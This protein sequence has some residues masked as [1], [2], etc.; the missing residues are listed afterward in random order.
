MNPRRFSAIASVL[1]GLLL[2]S[3]ATER[4]TWNSHE[5]RGLE[6][7]EHFQ[8]SRLES[9][10]LP[11]EGAVASGWI[12]SFGDERLN[13]LVAEALAHNSDLEQA[14]ARAD[15]AQAL[16]RRANAQLLPVAGAFAGV[17]RGDSGDGE[18]TRI[19]LG[20]RASWEADVWGRLSNAKRAAIFDEQSARADLV[21]ARH[22][23]AAAT[24][25]A[26]F[27]AIAAKQRVDVDE[28]SLAQ[29]ERVERITRAHFDAGEQPGGD[30]DVAAGQ[31]EGAR[32]LAQQSRGALRSALLALETLL[33]RYPAGEL[34]ATSELPKLSAP[35]PLGLPSQLLERRP[36]VVAAERA[37]AAAFERALEANAARLPRI[38]LTAEGG[39]SNDELKHLTDPSNVIWDLAAGLLAPLYAGGQLRADVD[40]ARAVRRGALANYLSVARH[41][42]FEVENAL[43]NEVTLR[44]REKSLAS[45]AQ[46]LGKARERSEE[47]YVQGEATILELDQVHSQL[48]QS[49]RDLV[50]AH[51]DLVLQRVALHLALGGSFETQP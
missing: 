48:Y 32:Q 12:A 50:A 10:A 7:R 18:A 25:Q 4:E 27:V 31:T 30:V 37:V 23:L 13:A 5:V 16:V 46:H 36:D 41:A 2:T 15:L 42:F 35:P 33:G 40:A 11:D 43:T 34:E 8:S 9:A 3:C 26:W 14:G 19:D 6:V 29:R 22:S 51:A 28:R 47:R 17:G 44:E 39:F 49:E 1:G 21:G 38:T 45:A 24:A 20:L